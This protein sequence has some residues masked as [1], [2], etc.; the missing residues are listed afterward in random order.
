MWINKVVH[1]FKDLQDGGYIYH[2]G[3]LYPREGVIVTKERIDELK[4]KNNK[5]GVPLIKR[6]Q[7]KKD[8]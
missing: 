1:S 7:V 2:E 8:N 6:E 3:D 4:G 5:I